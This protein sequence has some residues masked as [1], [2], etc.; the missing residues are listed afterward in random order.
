VPN[1]NFSVTG[2]FIDKTA[3]G[4]AGADAMQVFVGT[5]DGGGTKLA[6]G[7]VAQNRPDVA[8]ATG[9]PD[10]AASGFSA[11]VPSGALGSGTQVLSVY[12]H[13]GGKGWWYKQVSVNVSSSAPAA[14]APAPA[15]AAASGAQSGS[16][17]P[18]VGVENPKDGEQVPT[19]SAYQIIGYALDQNAPPNSGVAGSGINRVQVYMDGEPDNGGTYLGDADLGY[20][21]PV[22]AGYGS[23][24]QSA[25]WRLTF[26]PT[27]F[28]SGGHQLFVYAR[29]AVSGKENLA[30]RY[31]GII[32]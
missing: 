18:I 23:Q 21:D 26:K 9:T 17:L 14:S 10:W 25:G 27:E 8:A 28:H 2:W 19:R 22:A 12:L 6:D 30:L 20:S 11:T 5:M 1:G 3:Q 31:F 29:S 32:E 24:F 13:T 4:W 15:P 16:A 7:I